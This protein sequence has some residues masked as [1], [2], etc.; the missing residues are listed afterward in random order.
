MIEF[1][2]LTSNGYNPVQLYMLIEGKKVFVKEFDD[3]DDML[4]FI[5]RN[6]DNAKIYINI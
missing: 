6:Y 3:R 1:M 2:Y 4:K 5:E